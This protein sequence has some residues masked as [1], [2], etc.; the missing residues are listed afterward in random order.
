MSQD[1]SEFEAGRDIT[2][3]RDLTE[4]KSK[5][6]QCYPHRFRSWLQIVKKASFMNTSGNRLSDKRQVHCRFR[7]MFSLSLGSKSKPSGTAAE[8]R[9]LGGDFLSKRRFICDI[10]YLLLCPQ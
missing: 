7:G 6:E 5:L 2:Y 10:I 8:S 3:A 9:G 4:A 1:S